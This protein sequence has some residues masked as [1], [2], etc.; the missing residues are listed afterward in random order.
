[1]SDPLTVLQAKL[2]DAHG[3]AIAAADATRLVETRIEDA[4]LRGILRTMRR[5]A[6]ETRVR[7]LE[8]EAA[9]GEEVAREMLSH[10]NTVAERASDLAGAWF[11]AGTDPPS[12][13]SFVAMGEAAEVT[14][15]VA[16][17]ALALQAQAAGVAEL[18]DW[19]LPV[20]QRHLELAL[21]GAL[22]V[23]ERERATADRFG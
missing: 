1:M 14:T 20:Q 3:L 6:E 15:W 17:T 12:A 23:A 10:A 19:A 21:G 9:F 16:V 5:D 11:K 7:C 8:A 2:A 18:A 4:A 22:G 13:W